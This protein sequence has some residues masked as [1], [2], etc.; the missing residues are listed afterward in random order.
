MVFI[1]SVSMYLIIGTIIGF[2]LGVIL[3]QFKIRELNRKI[4]KDTKL[5][6]EVK[7]GKKSSSR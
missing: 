5:K 2:I 4:Y 1:D 6:K 7:N 3:M